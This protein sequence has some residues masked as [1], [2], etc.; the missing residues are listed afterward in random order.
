LKFE[1]AL[2][3]TKRNQTAI[4]AKKTNIVNKIILEIRAGAGGNQKK[5]DRHFCQKNKYCE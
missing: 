4:F 5:S 1:R 2:A 3:A